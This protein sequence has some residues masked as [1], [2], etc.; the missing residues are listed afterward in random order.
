VENKGVLYGSII[1]VFAS[2]FLM[3]GLLAYESY[4]AKQMKALAATIKSEA[5]PTVSGGSVQDY[6][7]YKTKMG[8]EGREMVQIPEGPFMMG[9]QDGGPDEAP[10]SSTIRL[11]MESRKYR[12]CVTNRQAPE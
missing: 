6:S 5:R 8:D 1:F 7:M 4:K 3:I 10:E 11:A 9:S 12:S 2:F